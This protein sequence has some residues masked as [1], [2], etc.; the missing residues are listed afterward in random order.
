MPE[1]YIKTEDTVRLLKWE[2]AKIAED[3]RRGQE[4]LD[5]AKAK[6]KGRNDL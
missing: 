6:C 3:T 2:Q 5:Y 4:L 1:N